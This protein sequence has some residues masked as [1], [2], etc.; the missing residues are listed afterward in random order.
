[1]TEA[2]RGVHSDP[3]PGEL[4]DLSEGLGARMRVAALPQHLLGFVSGVLDGLPDGDRL[5]HGDYHPGNVLVAAGRAAVIDRSAA[6]GRALLTAAYGRAYAHGIAPLRQTK[7]WP[8]VHAA[9]R[10]S[11]GIDSER[12]MLIERLERARRAATA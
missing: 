2:H 4:P 12:E 3:A 5:C 7:A 10:L 1:L 8:V 6:T 9:A 11:E